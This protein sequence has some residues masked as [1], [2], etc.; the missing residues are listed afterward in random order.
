MKLPERFL[1][2][3]ILLSRGRLGF[4]KAWEPGLNKNWAEKDS[5]K[6][7]LASPLFC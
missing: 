4:V 2:K 5:G 7:D 1:E 6:E 3:G